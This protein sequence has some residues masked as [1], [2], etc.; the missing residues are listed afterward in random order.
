MSVPY[1]PG[2]VHGYVGRRRDSVARIHSMMIE[3]PITKV[4]VMSD[5]IMY[6]YLEWNDD[7]YFHRAI[8]C[9]CTLVHLPRLLFLITLT[10]SH[11]LFIIF[12]VSTDVA[13]CC[14]GG[15]ASFGKYITISYK[16]TKYRIFLKFVLHVKSAHSHTSPR[17]FFI[18]NF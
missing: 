1:F 7:L 10:W 14:M 17:S 5:C 11:I 18:L 12:D 8:A 6:D 3:A 9:W 13:H 4:S 15:D 2:G 16:N